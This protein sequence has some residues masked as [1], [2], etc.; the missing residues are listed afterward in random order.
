MSELPIETDLIRFAW[1]VIAAA[2]AAARTTGGLKTMEARAAAE[3]AARDR[4]DPAAGAVLKAADKAGGEIHRLMGFLR[5]TPVYTGDPPA[6]SPVYLARCAPDHFI[7]PALAR[8]FYLR[9]GETPWAI[10]DEKRSLA[11]FRPPGTE[12]R[13]LPLK[14]LPSARPLPAGSPEDGWEELWRGYHRSVNNEDRKNPQLQ[15]RFIP[16]RYRKYLP[17]W[18]D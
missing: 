14:A 4:E 12:P 10:V 6:G 7:L 9:F 18:E 8:H 11:L 5:F 13:F 15:R 16:G 2:R 17:E 3:N 1:R